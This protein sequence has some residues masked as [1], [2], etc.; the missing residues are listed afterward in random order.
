[1]T[2]D[3]TCARGNFMEGR[4]HVLA[5]AYKQVQ[6]SYSGAQLEA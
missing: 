2:T 1:M 4:W 5:A 6:S 3:C